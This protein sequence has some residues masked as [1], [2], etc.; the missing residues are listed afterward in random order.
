MDKSCF[1]IVSII[2]SNDGENGKL[3][4]FVLIHDVKHLMASTTGTVCYVVP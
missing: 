4:K 2:W 3:E 1:V